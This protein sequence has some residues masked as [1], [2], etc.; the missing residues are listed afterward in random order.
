MSCCGNYVVPGAA[1]SSG[2]ITVAAG[3]G[4]DVDLSGG[5]YIV[6]WTGETLDVVTLPL[7]S[8]ASPINIFGGGNPTNFGAVPTLGPFSPVLNPTL[9]F[10]LTLAGQVNLSGN[11]TGSGVV[12]IGI[13][14]TIDNS[15][16]VSA[17]I[18]FQLVGGIHTIQLGPT[19]PNPANQTVINLTVPN[20]V[21]VGPMFYGAFIRFPGT[22]GQF[23]IMQYLLSVNYL[24]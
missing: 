17:E 3:F 12:S 2:N 20:A 7:F 4:I 16:V 14:R 11:N 19:I 23:N 13:Y 8:A 22:S 1:P 18:P 10:E 9:K 5:Q 15:V 24:I 21:A 6:S